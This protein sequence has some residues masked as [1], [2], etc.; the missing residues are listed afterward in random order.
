LDRNEFMNLEFF[1]R[2]FKNGK[3][4]PVNVK[5]MSEE[6]FRNFICWKIG[7]IAL[8]KKVN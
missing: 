2:V 3:W 6:E 5:D 4:Q 8:K 7:L 1:V